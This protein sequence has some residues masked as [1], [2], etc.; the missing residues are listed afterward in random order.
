VFVETTIAEADV[1]VDAWAGT[2]VHRIALQPTADEPDPEGVLRVA[3][4]LGTALGRR[5]GR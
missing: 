5:Q 1:A 4:E 3:A 2:G